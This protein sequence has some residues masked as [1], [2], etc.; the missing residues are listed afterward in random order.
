MTDKRQLI[1]LVAG[2]SSGDLHTASVMAEL[3][4]IHSGLTFKGIGGDLM[5][6]QGLEAIYHVRDFSIM[7]FGEILTRIF[8]LKKV[9]KNLYREILNDKPRVILLTDFSE[10]N[11]RFAAYL[12]KNHVPVKI[13]RLVSPQIWASRPGRIT[14][15]V[16]TYDCLC[17]ILPFEKQIYAEYK[18]FD[19]R[20]VGNPL[21]DQYRL[22]LTRDVFYERYGL[23]PEEKVIAI[24]PGSRKQEI[25][26]H[27]PILMRSVNLVKKKYPEWQ[28]IICKSGA[29][30]LSE[31]QPLID[32]FKI[33]T[34]TD[35]YQWEC[36]RYSSLVWSK[37]GTA[38][39]QAVIARTPG[40]IF[41]RTN[42]V[43]FA[44][45]KRIIKV[46]YI[47]LAN[48]IADEE[49]MPE[50]IQDDFNPLRM[51]KLT[52]QFLTDEKF[53]DLAITD[54]GRVV[55]KLGTPGAARKTAEAVYEYYLKS[56]KQFG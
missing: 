54:F 48:L 9:F 32:Q 19:C 12:K 23:N 37:S 7:G 29:V 33:Q 55:E 50:L 38:T 41:Y 14:R 22:R 28:F 51:A 47:G 11:L 34:C 15:I 49:L 40:L 46:K 13:V 8:F 17:C 27:M 26:H 6:K 25:K 2:E 45:A 31:Y 18:N 21:L 43:T 39:L 42:P 35:E 16:E 10:F 53:Y 4:R 44:I 56:I 1:Y 3:K 5:I 30:N 36:F 24:F 20:F 52:E